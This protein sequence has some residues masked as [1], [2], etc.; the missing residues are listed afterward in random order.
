M[1]KP[2]VA[3]GFPAT[4]LATAAAR[5]LACPGTNSFGHDRIKK[6]VAAIRDV[7]AFWRVSWKVSQLPP[8]HET[9]RLPAVFGTNR[10]GRDRMKKPVAAG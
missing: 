3:G 2:I 6:P 7:E 10:G 5:K 4:N 1:K 8:R 9:R